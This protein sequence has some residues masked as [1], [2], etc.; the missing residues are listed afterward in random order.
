[1]A[2]TFSVITPVDGSV[3][4]QRTFATGAEIAEAVRKAKKA[5]LEWKRVPLAERMARC[6]KAVDILV[7]R[8]G[9]LGEEVTW[10]MGRPLHVAAAEITSGYQRRARHFISLARNILA[11]VELPEERGVTRF[12]RHEPLGIVLSIITWNY[13]YANATLASLYPLVAGNAVL[14]KHS[15]QSPTVAEQVARAFTEAGVPDGALQALHLTNEDTGRLI[16]SGDIQHV[17]F[18]G[19]NMAGQAIVAAGAHA[20][21]SYSLEMGGKDPGYVRP[22]A[23][24]DAT[25]KTMAYDFTDNSGQSCCALGRIYVHEQVYDRFVEAFRE[26][27][28]KITLG[29]P[30]EEKPDIGPVVSVAAANKMRGQLADA[31]SK[32]GRLLLP[33]NRFDIARPGTAYIEPQV[34]FDANHMMDLATKETFGP[35]ICVT[36][37]SSDDAAVELMN[38]TE[39]GLTASVWTKDVDAAMRIGDQISSG[40]FLLNRCNHSDINLPWGGRKTSGLGYVGGELGYLRVTTPRGYHLHTGFAED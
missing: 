35:L 13:P 18:I 11:P 39:F 24:I 16:G 10:Q 25:A 19:S 12:I 17:E 1:M 23:D 4:T 22:D 5:Q 20:R 26:S 31:R 6:Q 8:A 21:V 36:K 15:P 28:A 14:L 7:S 38:D 30:I 34:V 27:A 40:T 29:H 32:G 37:V 9:P 2:E 3:Y 33:E